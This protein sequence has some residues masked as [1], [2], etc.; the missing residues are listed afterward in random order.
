MRT[1][2]PRHLGA[3]QWTGGSIQGAAHWLQFAPPQLAVPYVP[4]SPEKAL[5]WVP[6]LST[7]ERSEPF[8]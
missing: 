3:P 4:S 8:A 5:L 2:A 1:S 6:L 7:V